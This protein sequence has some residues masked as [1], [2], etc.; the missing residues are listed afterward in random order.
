MDSVSTSRRGESRSHLGFLQEGDDRG[1]EEAKIGGSDHSE[2][3]DE[4]RREVGNLEMKR[5]FVVS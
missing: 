3:S 4:S 5:L 1:N 2:H